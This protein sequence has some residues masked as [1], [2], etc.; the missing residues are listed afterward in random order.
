M[1]PEMM[2]M[3][4]GNVPPIM[5]SA[6]LANQAILNAAAPGLMQPGTNLPIPGAMDGHN[7]PFPMYLSPDSTLPSAPYLPYT[8]PTEDMAG[9]TSFDEIDLAAYQGQLERLAADRLTPETSSATWM[10]ENGNPLVG[11]A[12][13]ATPGGMAGDYDPMS[14]AE[15]QQAIASYG[16]F[17]DWDM[18]NALERQKYRDLWNNAF[19]GT[20]EL[21]P[22]ISL[23]QALA[24]MGT[25]R[26]LRDNDIGD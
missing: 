10:D 23:G 8:P 3:L 1:N 19:T 25:G 2:D 12:G 14:V 7:T 4:A 18:M 13:S 9:I 16:G 17:D 20:G 6:E 5:G 26:V 11:G 15:R 22:N 21:S 24:G